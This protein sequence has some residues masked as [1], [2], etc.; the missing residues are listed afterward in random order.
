MV[1]ANEVNP[2]TQPIIKMGEGAAASGKHRM[3]DLVLNL[4]RKGVDIYEK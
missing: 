4:I 3:H 1:L 2:G